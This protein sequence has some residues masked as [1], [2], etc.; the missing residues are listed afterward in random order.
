LSAGWEA[1][2]AVAPVTMEI[3]GFPPLKGDTIFYFE[4]RKG[5]RAA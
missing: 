1:D 2:I 3:V 5:R 4:R